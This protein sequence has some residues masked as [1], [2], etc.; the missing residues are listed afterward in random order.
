LTDKSLYSIGTLTNLE[1]LGIAGKGFSDEG[2][3]HIAKLTNL[4]RLSLFR[5]GQVTN[6]G[7]IEL[8]SL[9]SLKYLD[10]G[11]R[12]SISALK[13][14]NNLKNLNYLTL[15]NI[16]QDKSVLDIS[17][18]INL[19]CLSLSLSN[20]RKDKSVIY[21]S[22][23]N[24]DLKCLSKLHRLQ[25]LTL[26]GAG[27]NNEGINNI[28]GL[29]NLIYLNIICPE[30]T[31]INDDSLKYLTDMQRLYKINIRDGHFTDKALNYLIDLPSLSWLELT[32]DFAF[33]PKAIN[34]FKQNNPNI[35]TL[36]LMP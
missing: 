19:E 4:K 3:M 1:E 31:L 27:I 24:E 13:S 20:E 2:M 28:S 21:E 16:H 36:R 18:L 29:T 32:S 9:K 15:R 33:S 26:A 6:K 11:C 7:I 12:V 22:F 34:D 35:T 25:T 30:E 10:L 5:A 17:G 14:F 23:Q 8:A